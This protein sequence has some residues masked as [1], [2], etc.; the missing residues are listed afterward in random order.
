[1]Q[2]RL[3]RGKEDLLGQEKIVSGSKT[4]GFVALKISPTRRQSSKEPSQLSKPKINSLV[5]QNNLL[6]RIDDCFVALTIVFIALT[7]AFDIE[8]I[9]LRLRQRLEPRIQS[10]RLSEPFLCDR[11]DSL[12]RRDN[13]LAAKTL[14]SEAKTTFFASEIVFFIAAKI[15]GEAPTIF[16]T[17]Q[18]II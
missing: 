18:Q 7:I 1:L 4:I 15:V 17:T 13:N 11:G 12:P 16:A 8:T 9:F 2:K 3:F 14:F 10:L 5:S 6:C